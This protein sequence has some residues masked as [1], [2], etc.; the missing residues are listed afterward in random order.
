MDARS[1]LICMGRRATVRIGLIED[2]STYSYR[3]RPGSGDR[4][5]TL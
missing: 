2:V 4:G 3:L 5:R 1:G